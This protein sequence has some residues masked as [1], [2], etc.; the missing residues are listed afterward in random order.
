MWSI[1][2]SKNISAHKHS[3]L[4]CSIFGKSMYLRRFDDNTRFE[5]CVFKGTRPFIDNRFFI[6]QLS[7]NTESYSL[8]DSHVTKNFFSTKKLQKISKVI[9]L[10]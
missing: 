1:K 4:I 7:T 5:R 3:Q 10:A 9:V 8:N 6:I 2:E